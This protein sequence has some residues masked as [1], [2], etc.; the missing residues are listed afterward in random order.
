MMRKRIAF[1]K[2][3]VVM[4]LAYH[5]GLVIWFALVGSGLFLS[6]FHLLDWCNS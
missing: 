5:I 2:R 1:S 6:V 3:E 4:L